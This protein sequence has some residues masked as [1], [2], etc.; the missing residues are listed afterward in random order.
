MYKALRRMKLMFFK[1]ETSL[2]QKIQR[3][4]IGLR[5]QDKFENTGL[6][7]RT[8]GFQNVFPTIAQV[9]TGFQL[10]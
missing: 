6:C 3:L 1:R 10:G 4:S 5:N 9:A 7:S 8:G 2:L